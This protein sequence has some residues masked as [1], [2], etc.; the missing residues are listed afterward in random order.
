V[1]PDQCDE[2]PWTKMPVAFSGAASLSLAGPDSL[3]LL[4]GLELPRCYSLFGL[5][6]QEPSSPRLLQKS[7]YLLLISWYWQLQHRQGKTFIH[8]TSGGCS[9]VTATGGMGRI[10]VDQIGS[11]P[12]RQV[13]RS[14]VA[15][16][17]QW[18]PSRA[19]EYTSGTSSIACRPNSF[20]LNA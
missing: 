12:C 20:R 17:Q 18:C 14:Y 13:H 8:L 3:S 1:I 16:Y 4:F 2:S 6:C 10:S 7:Y 5:G 9:N 11:F 15:L 19:V